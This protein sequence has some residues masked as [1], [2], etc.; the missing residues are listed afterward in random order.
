MVSAVAPRADT[1]QAN[2]R[3]DVQQ[4]KQIGFR[5]ENL[6]SSDQLL[7]VHP[8]SAL[9]GS[10]REIIAIQ[11]NNMPSPQRRFDCPLDMLPPVLNK[12]LHL[13][14]QR[15]PSGKSG[16][17]Q[18][19]APLP[20]SRLL[21]P[22][23]NKLTGLQFRLDEMRLRGLAGTVD[24][25]NGNQESRKMM[26][27]GHGLSLHSSSPQVKPRNAGHAHTVSAT[28]P[29]VLHNPNSAHR[30]TEPPSPTAHINHTSVHTPRNLRC[31][32]TRGFVATR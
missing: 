1:P 28:F 8:A 20:R 21:R 7:W 22:N 9:I 3:V 18:H 30:N 23:H 25:F 24:A 6:I 4:N 15:E 12:G 17:T 10:S 11:N 31:T 26:M 27:S 14:L 29:Q 5:G 13:V 2:L 32:T 19:L 16:I